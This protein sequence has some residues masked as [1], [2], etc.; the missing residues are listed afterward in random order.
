[1]CRMIWKPH[2]TVAALLEQDGR[3]LLVEERIKGELR[4][5]QPA[6]HLEEG[7][8]LIEAA[9]RETIEEAGLI[10]TPTHLV[11]IYQWR[12]PE[13]GATYLRAAFTGTIERIIDNAVL[14]EGII[15]PVWLTPDE[16]HARLHQHRSPLVMDCIEDH[17]AGRRYPLDLIR[18]YA[19]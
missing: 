10:F 8:S 4:L 1:M 16:V 14:D 5:N 19:A 9:V 3:Y 11:G 17:R 15:G 18:H 12:A 13:T 2:A 7:E 6:G